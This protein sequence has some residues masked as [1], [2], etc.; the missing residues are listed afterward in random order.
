MYLT[1]HVTQTTTWPLSNSPYVD[2][3]K[4]EGYYPN[5]RYTDI[6]S[7]ASLT[8][9]TGSVVKFLATR[10][11]Q[12]QT[13]PYGGFDVQ[14]QGSLNANNV[15]FT[16]LFDD[17]GGDTNNDNGATQPLPGDWLNIQF[18]SGSSGDIENSV[19]RYGGSKYIGYYDQGEIYISGGSPAIKNTAI[20]YSGCS[21][22]HIA[23]GSPSIHY[24]DIFGNNNGI[25]SSVALDATHNY[26]GSKH[27]PKPYGIGNGFSGPVNAAPWS[28]IPFTAA[29]AAYQATLGLDDY[30]AYCGDPINT[31]TGAFVYQHKDIDIP[32]KGLPLEFDRTYNSNDLSDGVLGYGWSFNWQISV[33][34]LANGNV[35]ILRGDGRQDIFT[36]NPDGSYSPPA[37]RHD[38][39]S[40]NATDG[41]FRLLTQQQ[42][43]YNFN[44]DNALASEVSETG[45]TTTFAYNANKQLATITEP[46]GRTLSVTWG[47]DPA[48]AN[49]NRIDHITDPLTHSVTFSY[50]ATS[51]GGADLTSVT[52]QNN[53][54]TNYLYENNDHRITGITDPEGHTSAKNIY[55][56]G[57]HQVTSQKDAEDHLLSFDY[58]VP[59][60]TKM[61]RQ[62]DP[63][64]SA[65]DEITYF[66]YDSS[67]HLIKETDPYGKE[68]LYTY[69]GYGNR[70]SFTD[71]R[72]GLTKQVFDSYG[73]VTDSYKAYGLT[74]Q[75]HTHYT[76][77]AKNHPLTKTDSRG[78][79]TSYTYDVSGTYL[80]QVAYPAVTNYSAAVSNY[81]ESFTY[82]SDG[83]KATHTDAN[84]DITSYIYD[85][86][87]GYLS[88]ETRNTNR[89]SGDQITI[90][91]IFDDLGRKT[92]QVD[93]NGNVT[94][95]TYD[96]VG[97]LL[98]QTRH[99]T[100]PAVVA[101][102]EY[103]YDRANN[104]TL[105]IDPEGKNTS[106]SY[107]AT[108]RL[109][110][111]TDDKLNTLQFRYDVTGNKTEAK[112]RNGNWSYF[113][114]DKNNR[115]VTAKDPEE[116][117][118]S[119]TYDDEGNQL[120][121]TDPLG[122]TTTRTFDHL[123]RVTAITVPDLD[124]ATR[125]TSYAYDAADQ[126]L[127]ST[128][129]LS[130]TTSYSYDE[131]SRLRQSTDAVGSSTYT[132]YDGAG[133]I[134]KSRDALG[135]ETL[136]AYS[137]SDYLTSVTD[138]MGGVTGYG[139]DK[140][141]NRTSQTDAEGHTTY[142]GY[143]ELNRLTNE[144]VDAGG[145]SYLLEKSYSYN[146]AGH[147]LTD[148]TT[149]GTITYSYDGVYNLTGITDRQNASF[150]FTYDANHQQ[151]SATDNSASKTVSF[152]YNPRGLLSHVEDA[153]GATQDYS[154]DPAGNLTSQQDSVS[155]NNFATTYSYTPRNQ[156][157][158]VTR[159]NQ[160]SSFTY[161]AAGNLTY[162][163][164]PNGIGSF[165]NYDADN[166]VT[167]MEA[168]KNNG[169]WQQWF[170]QAYDASGNITQKG[171]STGL[172][173]TTYS[174]D[175][176]N[177]LTAENI[178]GYGNISYAYDH[179]GNR[180]SLT[181]PATGQTSYAYNEAN[182]L[183]SSTNNGTT[184]DYSYDANG[185]ITSKTTGSD[186]TSYSYN[187]MDKLTE[188]ATPSS[189]V[190]Y[191]YDAL[192]RRVQRTEGSDTRNIHLNA[193]SDLPDYW[194]DSSGSVTASLLRGADGLISFTLDPV[195]NP[196]L[197]Y[198][199]YSPHGDTT[200]IMDSSGNPFF[201]ARYDAFGNAI[202]GAG[203]WYG[204]TG[205]Y[206]R[207]SD[208]STGT[209][210]MGVREYDPSLG[211]FI[212][213]DPLK[214]TPTDPQQRN[215]YQYV[216]NDPLTR[217][218]LSGMFSITADEVL[219]AGEGLFAGAAACIAGAP[220]CAAVAV[221]ATAVVI[222]YEGYQIYQE[223]GNP[224][225]RYDQYYENNRCLMPPPDDGVNW[226]PGGPNVNY[227]KGDQLYGLPKEFRNWYHRQYKQ[228]GDP[229]ITKEEADELY[230]LWKEAGKPNAEGS[231]TE[232]NENE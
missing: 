180:T 140:N 51:D 150:T 75:Q 221:G 134:V 137:P 59:G 43:I 93:G 35:V 31:A 2:A 100:D 175:A 112:D 231:R 152:T 159:N 169:V 47:T 61:T 117:V 37:G 187:G 217:Y 136:Y 196:N 151:L 114:F 206:Q 127:S 182:Q 202:Q 83:T 54:T 135:H 228:K 212:S 48:Q 97:N 115:M 144:K 218:D 160:T 168:I 21:G 125:T 101:T 11:G 65:K 46:A 177:R 179:T 23:S 80:T 225:E 214:G 29:G 164:Y 27:G 72:G 192:G 30:C 98:T 121:A 33:S 19:I 70:D 167:S 131:L 132:A 18:E 195:S 71:R 25:S 14:A 129:P 157:A 82:N 223:G 230:E 227:S 85:S 45:Q 40:L 145:G 78:F 7:G 186:T 229:D 94:D 128:D 153:F 89:P 211:R 204:Y 84:G 209:I 77:N 108:N 110:T 66:Y 200:M 193:R 76:Y 79:T 22:V 118:T 148:E 3:G 232:K 9:E 8:I 102:T 104:R 49:F 17:Y 56:I 16:S 68:T 172:Y 143:D 183:I 87:T 38:A 185:A 166:R 26:W 41:T 92:Q 149:A 146:K 95:F 163:H 1:G 176:L 155:G 178:G 10:S 36:L 190:N 220:A 106:Y 99:F 34:P 64:D 142:Y 216:G 63:L 103:Q 191:A 107:T 58:S 86:N 12:T 73:N 119:F 203:L 181:N 156:M 198:Q 55:D 88:S 173:S 188:V 74:E 124:N 208:S 113:T 158:S 138:P 96:N 141:G 15:V 81:T 116:Y 53:H 122:R 213:Q 91:Y 210:E 28:R 5:D 171:E 199:L 139:Y 39:L 205:K 154:Y 109:D 6:K 130:H 162:K 222:G 170:S 174:Y 60:Q 123:N 201:T 24:N 13:N 161:D 165:Y 194:S 69:D 219:V 67:Y 52:D 32:T 50:T 62:M 184:T 226:G 111:V 147:L 189:T 120:T 133:N 207:Y 126:L 105:Q 44:S 4:Y 224:A 215:R 57:T 197:S 20:S 90:G 42:V